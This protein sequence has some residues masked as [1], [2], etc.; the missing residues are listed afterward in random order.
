[1]A[2][3][4]SDE[5]EDT[6]PT[7][8]QD[9]RTS[10]ARG[11]PRRAGSRASSVASLTAAGG[12][13]SRTARQ[14]SY[15]RGTSAGSTSR[16]AFASRSAGV[17]ASV[18][19]SPVQTAFESDTPTVAAYRST[20]PARHKEA[21]QTPPPVARPKPKRAVLSP[22]AKKQLEKRRQLEQA[23]DDF[24]TRKPALAFRTK[25]AVQKT[26]PSRAESK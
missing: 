2:P 11:A 21:S 8:V 6:L 5:D 14:P 19:A 22:E 24:F 17:R 20:G 13:A 23:E 15:E 16:T 12:P 25:K 10:T 9:S 18:S 7:L 26:E 1:M 4:G 3:Y